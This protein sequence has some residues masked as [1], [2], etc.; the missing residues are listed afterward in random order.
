MISDRLKAIF[1]LILLCS[2]G[3][4]AQTLSLSCIPVDVKSSLRGLSVVDNDIAW[5][6]GTKGTVGVTAD[7]GRTWSFMIV[8]GFDKLDFR[9]IYAFNGKEVVIANAGSPA[10]ILR[11]DDG[12]NKW[13]I[14]FQNN[15]PGCFFD[16]VDFWDEKNGI[17]YGDPL[18]GRMF[19]MI[20]SDG[21]RTWIELPAESRPAVSQGEASFAASG[22]GIRCYGKRMIVMVTGGSVSELHISDDAGKTWLSASLPFTQGSVTSGAFSAAFKEHNAII[23]GGDY[24]NEELMVNHIF[25]SEDRGKT[26]KAPEKPTGGFRECVIFISGK[27]AIAAGPGGVDCSYDK[28]LTWESLTHEKGFH[29]VAKARRGQLV[30]LAGNMKI[31]VINPIR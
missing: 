25:Y 3:A 9:S 18:D 1:I 16:G 14:V 4:V 26:W 6:S 15:D 30:L 22:T 17:I 7:G 31:A 21:G 11:T 12:G 10:Y 13:N 19:I 24:I 27:S 28:G 2:H 29:V 5:V 8:P 23:S 20:T